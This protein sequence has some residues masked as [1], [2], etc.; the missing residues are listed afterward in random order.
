MGAAFC[1]DGYGVLRA[2]SMSASARW[3]VVHPVKAFVWPHAHIRP[4]C[5]PARTS[6]AVL[7]FTQRLLGSLKRAKMSTVGR[8]AAKW[9]RAL[10]S[11]EAFLSRRWRCVRCD[12]GSCARV[13]CARVGVGG[14]RGLARGRAPAGSGW[15]RRK[16]APISPWALGF[17]AIFGRDCSLSAS[18]TW[19]NV[20]AGRHFGLILPAKP[21]RSLQM[22]FA[23]VEDG[24]SNAH[25]GPGRCWA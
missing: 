25:F 8:G 11:L 6:A 22:G 21:P 15:F 9:P 10:S 7:S 3:F 17:C 2:F 1:R 13:G 20:G 23:C 4:M 24:V 18:P 14:C 5:I 19:G 12:V 16:R